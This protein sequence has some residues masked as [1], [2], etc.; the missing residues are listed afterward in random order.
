MKTR[1]PTA[2]IRLL[3]ATLLVALLSGAGDAEATAQEAETG[4]LARIGWI[5]SRLDDSDTAMRRWRRGWGIAYA[6]LTGVQAS[7]WAL[8]RDDP[9]QAPS[10]MVGAA[11]SLLGTGAVALSPLRAAIGADDRLRRMPA[12]T[13][14]QID[15]K[16]D[17]AEALLVE[18]AQIQSAGK[19]LLNRL[20]GLS[21]PIASAAYLWFHEEQA[22]PAITQLLAGTAVAQIQVL[23]QPDSAVRDRRAYDR[24]AWRANIG[25]RRSARIPAPPRPAWHL[26]LVPA[27]IVVG[28]TLP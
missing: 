27:G 11:G 9:E 18:T 3:L 16:L 15:A 6:G 7:G 21:V 20:L 24:G 10:L 25:S 14:A 23:T 22:V 8:F 13:P 28:V 5:Q 26:G 19:G 4:K 12:S 1:P 2:P 17:R